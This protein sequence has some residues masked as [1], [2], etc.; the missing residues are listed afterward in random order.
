M[1]PPGDTLGTFSS[2]GN[3]KKSRLS[4]AGKRANK[5]RRK[6]RDMDPEKDETTPQ[7]PETEPEEGAEGEPA[8]GEGQ[9]GVE[10]KHGQPGINREKYQRDIEAK[11][12]QIAEL[13]AQL[14]EKSK[15]EEGRAALKAELDK[16]KADMADERTDH[17]LELAGCLNAKAA[18]AL[19]GD[20]DGDVAKLKEACPYL[21]G[22]EKKTGSTGLKPEGAAGDLDDKLDKAF[23]IKK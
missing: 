21:F 16:L 6:E 12:K 11:D 15:T 20:Y 10:D 1:A 14:D 23:G 5:P 9:D 8:A 22:V 4:R 3:A 7:E 19:L 18:K 2:H 13:Q 17:R